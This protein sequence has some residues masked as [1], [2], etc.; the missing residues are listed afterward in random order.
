MVTPLEVAVAHPEYVLQPL[1]VMKYLVP[2]LSGSCLSASVQQ[3]QQQQQQ[4][5]NK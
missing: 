1:T 2:S 5:I 4:Q 3:Q